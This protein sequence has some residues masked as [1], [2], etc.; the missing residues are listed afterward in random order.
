MESFLL[1]DSRLSMAYNACWMGC[2]KCKVAFYSLIVYFATTMGTH[3]VAAHQVMMQLCGMCTV[4]GEPFSQ[5][6]QSFMPEL[7]EG[8]TFH[9]SG[10]HLEIAVIPMDGSCRIALGSSG[11]GEIVTALPSEIDVVVLRKSDKVKIMGGAQRGSTGKLIGVD[12][13]DGIV[14]VDDTLDVK[15]LDMDILAKLAQ[16]N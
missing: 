13:S 15:I 10:E 8:R 9:C 3:T 16:H 2:S 1:V 4:F 12:G 11:N 6:A 14:K 7:M 5:T